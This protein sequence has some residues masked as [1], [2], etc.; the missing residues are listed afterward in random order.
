MNEKAGRELSR[1]EYIELAGKSFGVR[2]RAEIIKYLAVAELPRELQ[3]R[4]IALEVNALAPLYYISKKECSGEEKLRLLEAVGEGKIAV[5]DLERGAKE[6]VE[7]ILSQ[8]SPKDAQGSF[9]EEQPDADEFEVVFDDETA[10]VGDE[11]EG[12]DA[13]ETNDDEALGYDDPDKKEITT[14]EKKSE[15]QQV[16]PDAALK[17]IVKIINGCDDKEQLLNLLQGFIDGL[18]PAQGDSL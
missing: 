15:E 8:K 17:K 4:A 3:E 11:G 6:S 1:N 16:A 10:T 12:I 9:L 14:I 13:Q 2:S 5:R 7:S 18:L